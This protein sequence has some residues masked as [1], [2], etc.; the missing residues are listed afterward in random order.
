ME[1]SYILTVESHF[2]QS[3]RDSVFEIIC[4]TLAGYCLA[5]VS[6]ILI[7]PLFGLIID[8]EGNLVLAFW[9]T[10]ISLVRGYAFR[11]LFNW[12]ELRNFNQGKE[13]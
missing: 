4:S 8:I 6:Q 7:F 2:L 10:V 13:E 5:V 12:K 11:R 9:F 1:L 3:K